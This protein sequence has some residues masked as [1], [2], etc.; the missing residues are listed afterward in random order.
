M[1]LI[2]TIVAKG[3]R[4]AVGKCVFQLIE[5]EL[6]Y[7]Q[8]EAMMSM[9]WSLFKC[10]P[11]LKFMKIKWGLF[12]SF[13]LMLMNL[14]CETSVQQNSELDPRFQQAGHVVGGT[15]AL[16]EEFPFLVNIW[17]I[18]PKDDYVSHHCGGSLIH[19]KWV[20]T[21]AHCMFTDTAGDQERV[22]RPSELRL[23]LGST[24]TSG[25][26][27]RVVGIKS[28]L[29]HPEYQFPHNDFA[30]IE[31]AQEV[32]A[33]LPVKLNRVD[34]GN[35]NK[36]IVATIAGWGLT[37]EKGVLSPVQLQKGQVPLMSREECQ[38]D[39]LPQKRSWKITEDILCGV[40]E[41]GKKSSCPGD[42]GGPL[43][44]NIN[45]QVKQI[46]VVSW[47]SSC[48]AGFMAS[49]HSNVDAYSNVSSAIEWIEK[50]TG[51]L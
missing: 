41:F 21:A 4:E 36:G 13:L 29:P 19:K 23:Y 24:L 51:P 49:L 20:L 50:N 11:L 26:G 17:M 40:S 15:K 42:S 14:S 1:S 5:F 27:G 47:G 16:I 10:T 22:V 8:K 7:R 34:L 28:I 30:L 44:L 39:S 31:L 9:E 2:G 35:D 3:F 12:F 18:M 6:L 25:E 38:K 43:V 37:D 46:G 33:I 48:R 45:G 32:D